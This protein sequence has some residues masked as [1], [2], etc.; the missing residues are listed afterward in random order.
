MFLKESIS[1][2][3]TELKKSKKI[4]RRRYKKILNSGVSVACDEWIS[5]NYYLLVRS[6]DRTIDSLKNIRRSKAISG[7]IAELS[8]SACSVI[9]GSEGKSADIIGFVKESYGKLNGSQLDLLSLAFETASVITA[10]RACSDNR[11]EY[12]S[13][14]VKTIRALP[15]IDFEGLAEEYSA[16]SRVFALDPSGIYSEMDVETKALYRKMCGEIAIR[17]RNREEDVALQ[18]VNESIKNNKQHIGFALFE[19]HGGAKKR[20]RIGRVCI[21]S[22]MLIPFVMSFIVGGICRNIT[23]AIIL[24]LPFTL[25][26]RSIIDG[27]FLRFSDGQPLPRLDYKAG[28]PD[29][30]M[31]V[32]VVSTMVGVPESCTDLLNHLEKIYIKNADKN[33]KVC[34][35]ADLPEST[36]PMAAGDHAGVE[37]LKRMTDKLNLKYG[38]SFMLFV[39]PRSY[40]STQNAYAGKERKRGAI[41]E[42]VRYASG[43]NGGFSVVCGSAAELKRAKYILALDSDTRLQLDTVRELVSV[44]DHP[45]NRPVVDRENGRVISGYGIISPRT[46]TAV[47]SAGRTAFSRIITGSGGV[48]SYD[49]LSKN[50]YQDLFGETVFSGKGLI[51]ISAFRICLDNA[52][53]EEKVLSHDILEGGYLRCACASD[54]IVTDSCPGTFSAWLKRQH[55]WIRGDWQ[56]ITWLFNTIPCGTGKRKNPYGRLT[57]YFIFDNLLR[58]ASEVSLLFLFVSAAIFPQNS[59]FYVITALLAHSLGA[60]WN[61]MLSLLHGGVRMV[62]GKYYSRV[63]PDALESLARAGF[64]TS[65]LLTSAL[66]TADAV[67]RSIYRTT[68]SNRRLLE[69]TTA[70]Q[71]EKSTGSGILLIYAKRFVTLAAGVVL[72]IFPG[73]AVKLLGI[74]TVLSLPLEYY[75]S[76]KLNI[77]VSSKKNY[78]EY[79]TAQCADMWRYYEDFCNAENN[80]LPP[81][82]Y[83]ESPVGRLAC[84]TSPTNIGFM[85]LSTFAARCFGFIEDNELAGRISNTLNTIDKLEKYHGNLLNWYDTVT[86]KPL[87]PRYC[88]S[89][90]SGNFKACLIALRNGLCSLGKNEI[91]KDVC[92]RLDALIADTDLSVMYNSRRKL[93]HIGIDLEKNEVS[94]S[95][96]DLMMSEARLTSYVSISDRTV[97]K[98]HWGALS[99]TVVREGR[100]SGA[101]SWTGTAFEYY[102][103]HVLLP[104]Y[105][106]TLF[107]EALNF[108]TYCQRREASMLGKPFGVSESGFFSFDRELNYQ[109]KAHGVS[110]LALKKARKNEYVISPYS[111]YLMFESCPSAAFSNLKK[112]ARN[113]SAYGKYGFYEAID[114]T[115]DR[116]GGAPQTVQ[117]YMAHH[118]G[119]SIC[120]VCNFLKGDILRRVFMSGEMSAGEELLLEKIPSGARVFNDIVESR[121]LKKPPRIPTHAEASVPLTPIAPSAKVYSNGAL[122]AVFSNI[123]ISRVLYNGCDVFRFSSDTVIEPKGIFA[124]VDTGSEWLTLQS[125]INYS[126]LKNQKSNLGKN[127]ADY[128]AENQNLSAGMRIF[129]HPNANIIEA[130]IR[131]ESKITKKKSVKVCVY[132]EPL[133]AELNSYISHKAFSMLFVTAEKDSSGVYRFSRRHRKGEK[134]CALAAMLLTD[135][136]I[137]YEFSRETVLAR[138]ETT[139]FYKNTDMF[140]GIGNGLPDACCAISATLDIAP[141]G[142]SE[143][144]LMISVADQIDTAAAVLKRAVEGR[145]STLYKNGVST[146]FESGTL[147][148]L[149]LGKI[150]P[151][152][153][154]GTVGNKL[155]ISDIR[156]TSGIRHKLWSA[157][158]SGDVPVVI[159]PSNDHRDDMIVKACV[160]VFKRLYG[161]HLRF[162][163][164]L[165][166]VN[167]DGYLNDRAGRIN[168]LLDSED[169]FAFR[170]KSSGIH[171]VDVSSLRPEI[172]SAIKAF[173]CAVIEQDILDNRTPYPV[174]KPIKV[175]QSLPA[176][177]ISDKGVLI[178]SYGEFGQDNAFTILRKP[179]IPWC[180]IMANEKFGTLLS[181]SD[182]GYTWAINSR[183]NRLTPWYNDTRRGNNGERLLLRVGGRIFDL[184]KGSVCTFGK[185]DASYKCEVMGLSVTIKVEVVGFN[186]NVSVKISSD[187]DDKYELC[188]YT[189][190]VLGYARSASGCLVSEWKNSLLT[191]HNS[192]E[193][194]YRGYMAMSCDGVRVSCCCDRISVLSGDWNNHSLLPL[195][196]GCACIVDNERISRGETK[197]ITF[198]LGWVSESDIGEIKEYT[199]NS[200]FISS[201]DPYLDVMFNTWLPIQFEK[202]RMDSRTAFSQSSGAY[203]FRDQLQD[204]CAVMLLCPDKARAHILK[205]CNR[206]FQEGDVLHWWHEFPDKISGVRTRCSDDMLWLCYA[207]SEY[208]R[209]TSDYGLLRE[210][211][212]YIIAPTLGEGEREIYINDLSAGGLNETVFEHCMRAVLRIRT[213]VHSLPLIGTCDWNDGFSEVGAEGKGESV[214]LAMFA[215][216]VLLRMAELAPKA[217]ETERVEELVNKADELKDAVLRNAEENDRF[218]RAFDDD[219]N[220]LGADGSEECAI[221]ILPQAFAVLSGMFIPGETVEKIKTALNLLVDRNRGTISL[222][223]PPFVK[224]NAGYI[225]SYPAGIREN[226]GQYTHGAV[227]LAAAAL[228]CGMNNVGY[229]LLRMMNPAVKYSER[230]T[231]ERYK[232]E[233]YYM[234]ADVYTNP[235]CE[236]R[237]GWTM[238][239]GAA[240]WYYRTVLNCLFGISI[241]QSEISVEP[242]L[243]DDFGAATVKMTVFGHSVV[244]NFSHAETDEEK[245]VY[246][247]GTR[248]RSIKISSENKDNEEYE[249][250]Y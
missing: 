234:A 231:G 219:G 184:L 25:M 21:A 196:D 30:S 249:C 237:A 60:L 153:S 92:A 123:G 83:Q 47:D 250:R 238:Y 139:G 24:F 97:P 232:A 58:E 246:L 77:S 7:S 54:I 82:N 143:L 192:F 42:L 220:P 215:Y 109:Y 209:L 78:K 130:V 171:V 112:I 15:E 102:M 57:R 37:A 206:Q 84:R 187:E 228:K 138:G 53:P 245:G 32:A 229:E 125:C 222:F 131:L 48:S 181:D 51:D 96:Y 221:D 64:L 8:E 204:A 202:C 63:L 226:G 79:L 20:E 121:E 38:N 225:T 66:N 3:F 93:F 210:K 197:L 46:E 158:I 142:S 230:T 99:R 162:D 152:I 107:Y 164:V 141:R 5:D 133:L 188:Y 140:S 236:G 134:S 116:T 150:L 147:E 247:R 91:F 223:T 242:H 1:A 26:L 240:G 55:R 72:L 211:T 17:D 144:R 14:A 28:I 18:I 90:D 2:V 185:D 62:T 203:G 100:Y 94:Q 103:P 165:L 157:G 56:N 113:Y 81:D 156:E 127:F 80:Y 89:V 59:I 166:C 182:L 95:Y 175:Y 195:G 244:L 149:I 159:C 104:V 41:L 10:A 45:L 52:F 217:G 108:C 235:H 50:I 189:E 214:W 88:S 126:C 119:M 39:R 105:K 198:S 200:I 36:T 190:P 6:A 16:I 4:L 9:I 120:A 136:Q 65:T 129:L 145:K 11:L 163:L 233:P 179:M 73:V 199:R 148:N 111:T 43:E 98:K 224:Y 85:L 13:S 167:E 191:V 34:I 87:Y 248:V 114:F 161:M 216:D 128:M 154:L 180:H 71:A 208:I 106:D 19:K 151:Q 193:T 146:P 27:I 243:P 186:K 70:Q 239:T 40:I 135:G 194:V 67:F 169:V 74:I 118:I 177:H 176:K 86:L 22:R 35:L 205:C 170:E 173:S 122:T 137:S 117:S 155:H 33:F 101:V 227:W 110:V 213:G 201:R 168:A 12:I 178:T 172:I 115:H 29:N 183:E 132:F 160:K 212:N 49:R 76:K 174:F 75:S 61:C 218:V 69:W 44:A 124:A 23:V 241:S 68:I 207:V 31:T